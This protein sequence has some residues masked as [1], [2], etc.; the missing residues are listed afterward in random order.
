[1]EERARREMAANPR[2]RW[3]GDLPRWKALRLLARCRLLLVTSVSEGGANVVSEALACSVPVVSSDI[4]GSVGI[5]GPDY[6]GYF[7]VG[8]AK[9]LAGLLERVADDSFY[10]RLSDRCRA[11]QPLV[12]PARE[13][14]TWRA[15]LQ[16]L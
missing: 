10:R 11:L 5:L 1:M 12:D 16:S 13:R 8:D 3:F 4:P 6:P 7:P 9:A 14:E 15:L 2:Y